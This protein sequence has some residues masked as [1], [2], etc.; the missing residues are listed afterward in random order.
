MFSLVLFLLVPPLMN[1]KNVLFIVMVLDTVVF[2]F[3]FL[4]SDQITYFPVIGLVSLW[5]NPHGFNFSYL[6]LYYS[7]V[8]EL[9]E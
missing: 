7:E 1:V 8:V 5:V 3:F 2:F 6:N 4:P 9:R